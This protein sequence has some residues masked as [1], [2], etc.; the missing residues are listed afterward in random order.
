MSKMIQKYTNIIIG[1]GLTGLSAAFHLNEAYA[2]F[3]KLSRPGGLCRSRKINGFVFDYAPHIL[4]TVDS[5]A[6][7]FIQDL[8]KG[9]LHIQNRQAHIY[10]EKYDTYTRFPFQAHLHGLPDEDIIACLTGLVDVLRNPDRPEPQNYRGVLSASVHEKIFKAGYSRS[11]TL[12][13]R[14]TDGTD[15][16]PDLWAQP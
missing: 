10:H 11:K 1:G 7:E 4:Y 6:G 3:E 12:K 5:Y 13:N 2:V 9:N 14:R 8:L 16:C 15:N